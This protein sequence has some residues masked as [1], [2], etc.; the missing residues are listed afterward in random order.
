MAPTRCPS[1]RPLRAQGL[2][3]GG[4]RRR[5]PGGL[6]DALR[7]PG[8]AGVLPVALMIAGEHQ[9]RGY[10]RA[11]LGLV[12]DRVRSA[13]GPELLTSCVPGEGGPRPFYEA[14]ASWPPARW[15]TARRSSACLWADGRPIPVR[16]GRGGALTSRPWRAAWCCTWP[17]SGP[18]S[19]AS[20]WPWCR[21]RSARQ[22]T[23]AQVSH[24]A[25]EAAAWLVRNQGDDGRYL[26]GYDR[27][28]DA[29]SSQYNGTRHAGVTMS[30]YQYAAA[31][32][33]PEVIAAGRPGPGLHARPPGGRARLA[34]VAAARRGGAT[35]VQR[36]A[37]RGPGDAAAG[38]GR[39]G[40]RRRDAARRPLPGGPAAAR[41]EDVR[42][43]GR[44]DGAGGA[45]VGQVRHR[46]G[47]L[48][49]GPARRGVPRRGLGRGRPAH[50][51]LPGPAPRPGRGQLH[52]HA[53]P[54]GGLRP[55]GSRPRRPRRGALGLLP[56]TGGL[57]RHPPA[58]RGPAAGDR[59]QPGRCAGCRAP[60][61]GWGRPARAS[62]PSG[63]WP[64]RTPA[65]PTCSPTWRSAWPASPG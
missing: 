34:G 64:R 62:P 42:P 18:A 24:A 15:T 41:R 52:P 59:H 58:L 8:E 37:H 16:G 5:G 53:R 1:P 44:G 36:P 4:L 21:P 26:Y 25:D 9:R 32:G 40:L 10:G 39:P 65:W 31:A 54:L 6:R 14:S 7:R 60:R 3:P 19:P 22:V 23:A 51:R 29:V 45:G 55:G 57:L 28:D 17:C 48:G 63:A 27:D 30:L 11:A 13:R 56:A 38:H 35:G 33:R 2:V 61:P 43:V 20:A 47:G 46:R 50:P 12:I 49:A